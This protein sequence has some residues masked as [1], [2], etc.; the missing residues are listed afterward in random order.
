MRILLYGLNFAP[1]LV[2]I[3]RFT[4][5]MAFHLFEHDFDVR[6]ITA[7]PYYPAWRVAQGYSGWHYQRESIQGVE[8]IRCPLWVPK[9]PSKLK[10]LPHLLSLALS[11][12]PV[13]I[14]QALRYKPDLILCVIPTL[15]SAPFA[16]LAARLSKA[17][18]WLH[19]QDFELDAALKLGMLLGSKFFYPLAHGFEKFILTRFDHVS[20]ISENMRTLCI[21]KGVSTERTFLLLN[22]V[23][24]EKICP[25]SIPSAM[26]VEFNISPQTFVALYHGNMGRKQGLEL[27][28]E[29]ARILQSNSNVLFV[30]CGAGPSKKELVEQAGSLS[31]VRFLELQP[32]ER[33]NDLV[34]L[35][36][37]HL[38]PQLAEAADL[39]MPSKLNTMLASGRPVIAG[40]NPSTQVAQ[41]LDNIGIV[42]HPGD[43]SELANAILDL[44]N[45]SPKRLRLGKLS[46]AYACQNLNKQL[47][48]S[49]LENALALI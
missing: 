15:F 36:D 22:W 12:F 33:L 18:C 48:L 47:I 40:A 11:S 23:D 44:L 45:D 20:T 1:E 26:R 31:N 21:Q 13:I 42:V 29:T 7:P 28:I 46:R 32:E 4:G 8:I 49:Q 2:G 25:L 39:V 14:L 9:H 3:G 10:R 37:V 17:K 5:E 38:L 6:V 27:L 30:L 34:N 43:A 16:L 19:V 41:V 35:A 24:T